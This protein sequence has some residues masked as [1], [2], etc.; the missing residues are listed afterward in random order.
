MEAVEKDRLGFK[1]KPT[2]KIYVAPDHKRE[3][4]LRELQHGIEEEA[5]PY[6]VIPVDK[7]SAVLLAWEASRASRLEVGLGLD[8][9]MLALHYGKLE[10]D[11]PL[12]TISARAP[13]MDV[14][15][16]GANAARLVKKTPFKPL[17]QE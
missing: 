3:Q 9:D 5:I 4:T 10:Q 6:E 8:H 16:M 13:E 17:S 15:A 7:Q 2:I 11:H 14:R 1:E 12:F